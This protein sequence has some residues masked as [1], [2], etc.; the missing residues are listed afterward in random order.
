MRNVSLT[1]VSWWNVRF[2]LEVG[3]YLDWKKDKYMVGAVVVAILLVW[4]EMSQK[5]SMDL[6]FWAESFSQEECHSVIEYVWV[7]NGIRTQ[8]NAQSAAPDSRNGACCRWMVIQGFK[9]WPRE[10]VNKCGWCDYNCGRNTPKTLV[11]QPKLRSWTVF[12]NL[13]DTIWK[14][15]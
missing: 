4:N 7:D 9:L 3:W 14:Y 11:L 10:I 5:I 12:K 13:G 6:L 15:I 1:S 8:D 2:S